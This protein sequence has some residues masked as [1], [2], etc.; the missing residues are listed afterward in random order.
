MSTKGTYVVTTTYSTIQ[1][2]NNP[3]FQTN[4][5]EA[6]K[7]PNPKEPKEIFRFVFESEKKLVYSQWMEKCDINVIEGKAS[8]IAAKQNKLARKADI[9][10]S[11]EE[12]GRSVSYISLNGKDGERLPYRRNK[13]CKLVPGK[14]AP[15]VIALAKHKKA[16]GAG[17]KGNKQYGGIF[18][19]IKVQS[20]WTRITV[21]RYRGIDFT[22]ER[23]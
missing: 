11:D 3:R 22:I 19:I 12:T 4:I 10:L 17:T 18:P 21:C 20:N 1:H 2:I 5:E 8:R 6:K 23:K 14:G 7:V 16:G 15:K 9:N 13:N